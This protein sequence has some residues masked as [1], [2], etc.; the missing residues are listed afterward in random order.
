[1][2]QEF[3]KDDH[4]YWTR[5]PNYWQPGLPLLDGIQE[6][7]IPDTMTAQNMMLAG[8]ADEWDGGTG[9]NQAYLVSKGYIR[10]SGWCGLPE[11]IWPNTADPNSKFQDIRLRQALEY[12]MDKPTLAKALGYGY[13]V[14]M[15]QMAP[16]GE[17]GY[18]PNYQAPDL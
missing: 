6:R 14:P 4:L 8:Q 5:N 2:L 10:D 1:M 11:L 7:F 9:Q 17:W 13:Y 12:A 3:V 15:A 18:D 16:A